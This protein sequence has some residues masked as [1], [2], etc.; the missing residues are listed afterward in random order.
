MLVVIS[1]V[2]SNPF[3]LLANLPLWNF[4]YYS[5]IIRQKSLLKR[6]NKTLYMQDAQIFKNK[7]Y[8]D[9]HRSN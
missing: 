9:L 1:D 8:L 7:E 5:I 2:L 4:F 3:N 6:H